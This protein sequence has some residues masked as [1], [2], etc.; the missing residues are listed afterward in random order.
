MK[1]S[2]FKST[3]EAYVEDELEGT[4]ADIAEFLLE[5]RA[6]KNKHDVLMFNMGEFKKLNDPTVEPGRIYQRDAQGA[7]T[8]EYT[9]IANTVRRCKANLLAIHG[10]VLDVDAEM[11]MRE[12]GQ[13]FK[14]V[15]F[16]IY[17][18]F[19]HRL[20]GHTEKF[21]VVIPFSRPLLAPDIEGRRASI[22]QH[23][24]G[25]DNASFTVSQSFYLHSGAHPE[26]FYS[27][28][29][30][31]DPYGFEYAEP[32]VYTAE[33]PVWLS[34][35]DE[36]A[37]QR[38]RTSTLA[39]LLTCSGLHYA[40]TNS[41]NHGILTLVTICRSAGISYEE[42]SAICQRI[43]D[44]DSSVHSAGVQH[45][46]WTSWDGARITRAKRDA[47]IKGYGGTILSADDILRL[48]QKR[49]KEKHDD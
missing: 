32:V 46:A 47:F 45:Q 28:G 23:F 4:W 1:L 35:F 22:K 37:Q 25:V 41:T 29:E 2:I 18:T 12:V 39:S 26:V 13:Q 3:Y 11:S 7:R 49:K 8:G 38:Y 16:L 30:I 48:T 34:E 10:L 21:R 33:S 36:N 14:G 9:Q 43:G 17:S 5:H 19:R 42:F 15:E 40:G 24:P 44:T 6:A 27:A 31:L 20:D